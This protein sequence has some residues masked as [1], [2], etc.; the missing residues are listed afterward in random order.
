MHR[1]SASSPW[2]PIF[3]NTALRHTVMPVVLK[4]MNT[5]QVAPEP[6]RTPTPSITQTTHR[7]LRPDH[8]QLRVR[9]PRA[10]PGSR[11]GTWARHRHLYPHALA[12]PV[13]YA[14]RRV[15]LGL[16]MDMI[17]AVVWAVAVAM[18]RADRHAHRGRRRMVMLLLC[19]RRR[20]ARDFLRRAR[21]K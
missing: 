10:Q 2:L 15:G 6:A 14:R 16:V 13:L 9:R 3:A 21:A 1:F 20:R 11:Y 4:L 12:P 18:R 17:G 19:W 8:H 5:S 7:A